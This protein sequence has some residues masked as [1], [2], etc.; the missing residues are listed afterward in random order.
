MI[1]NRF[2]IWMG[3][4]KTLAAVAKLRHRPRP[5]AHLQFRVVPHP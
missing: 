4:K 5:L 1:F 3:P 2:H